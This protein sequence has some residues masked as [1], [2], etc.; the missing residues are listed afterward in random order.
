M[1]VLK[2]RLTKNRILFCIY[3]IGIV[4]FFLY[5]GFPS[6]SIKTYLVYRLSKVSPQIRVT[7]ERVKPALPP[8]IRLYNVDLYHREN[9]WVSI[10]TIKIIPQVL[11]LFGTEKAFSFSGNAYAG[12][13]NGNAEIVSKSP[14]AQMEVSTILTGIQV[15]DVQAIQ[16]VSEYEISGI[17]SGKFAYKSDARNQ[18]LRGS[19]TLSDCRVELAVPLF[20]QGHLTFKAVTA[21]V[22]LNNQTLTIQRSSLVGTQMDASI[23]GSI[24]FDSRTGRQALHLNATITPHHVFW[25]TLKKSPPFDIF[26]DSKSDAQSFPVKIRGTMDAPELSFN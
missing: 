4:V 21:D 17:L 24:T 10:E 11:S 22:V 12:M 7:I 26:K 3:I 13:L 6:D 19:F 14:V 16:N 20:N 18:T 9:V 23:S 15:K 8:G 5:I 25:A 1:S 2:I